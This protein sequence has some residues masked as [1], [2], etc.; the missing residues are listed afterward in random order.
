MRNIKNKFGKDATMIYGDWSIGR[1][2]SNF[3]S[4]PNISINPAA[5]FQ[6]DY[7]DMV[8]LR[9]GIGNFQNELQIDNT[10]QVSFQPSLG[11]GFK[12]KG[13]QI[14]Y[15]FTDIG[16]QSVALYS[17]VFSLKLDFSIFR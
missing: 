7:N 4:T 14:D 15:A 8:F 11:A 2:M 12:Y 9:T 16:D 17:N 5:G 6:F 10:E 13:I 1:Q 3:I